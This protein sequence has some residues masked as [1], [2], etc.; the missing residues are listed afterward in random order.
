MQRRQLETAA[1]N[2]SY[3]RGLLF[4]PLMLSMA[5]GA[6]AREVLTLKAANGALGR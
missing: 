3:L 4:V 6:M 1:A 5:K 2:Y